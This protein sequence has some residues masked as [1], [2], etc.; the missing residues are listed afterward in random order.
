MLGPVGD[1]WAQLPH[2]IAVEHL[3]SHVTTTVLG[4]A[5]PAPPRPHAPAVLLASVPDD[6]HDL[7][8]VALAAVLGVGGISTTMLG[9]AT[10]S[11]VLA[12]AVDRRRPGVVVLHA[13]L[14][15]LADPGLL[16]GAGVRLASGPGWNGTRLPPGVL[17]VDDLTSAVDAVTAHVQT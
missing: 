4:E 15:E 11:G 3:I 5:T 17:H 9:A 6:Q 12:D 2:G 10:P 1:R 14:R 13:Q 8:L 16:L 7:P